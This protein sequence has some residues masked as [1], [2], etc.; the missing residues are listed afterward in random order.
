MSNFTHRLWCCHFVWPHRT[1]LYFWP[2]ENLIIFSDFFWYRFALVF[3]L[4]CKYVLF[5]FHQ[6]KNFPFQFS[7]NFFILLTEFYI[8]KCKFASKIP[9]FEIGNLQFVVPTCTYL[10]YTL[11]CLFLL[12]H[13]YFWGGCIDVQCKWVFVFL[14]KLTFTIN[15]I[16][17]K[18]FEHLTAL[19][20]IPYAFVDGN[21]FHQDGAWKYYGLVRNVKYIKTKCHFEP[22]ID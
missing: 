16:I 3:P 6:Y 21:D 8:H 19:P 13:F 10:L 9:M 15:L 4:L 20:T 5:D 1:V 22:M 7:I 14:L 17:K 12:F 11:N 2:F 18:T